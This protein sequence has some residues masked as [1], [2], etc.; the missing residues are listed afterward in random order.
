MGTPPTEEITSQPKEPRFRETVADAMASR[1][2]KWVQLWVVS[3][4]WNQQRYLYFCH[5]ITADDQGA[6]IGPKLGWQNSL[7]GI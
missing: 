4:K 6:D 1:Y 2:S 5:L 3:N 7:P